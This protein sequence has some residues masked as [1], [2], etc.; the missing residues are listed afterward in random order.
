MNLSSAFPEVDEVD[1]RGSAIPLPIVASRS[2][3]HFAG[4]ETVLQLEKKQS[5][6]VYVL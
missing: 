3:S 4:R 6:C 1:R 5:I 2:N